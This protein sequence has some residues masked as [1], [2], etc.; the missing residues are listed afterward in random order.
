VD[1][2]L[3]AGPGDGSTY[4]L[5]TIIPTPP[6]SRVTYT[7]YGNTETVGV[8]SVRVPIIE[9]AAATAATTTTTAAAASAAAAL[10]KAAAAVADPSRTPVAVD[11]DAA[12]RASAKA[13]RRALQV[14]LGRIVASEIEVPIELGNLV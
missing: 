10:K 6:S 1:A 13:G 5:P 3:D 7:Q 4:G 2:V 14:G 9:A 12:K 8:D 11:V